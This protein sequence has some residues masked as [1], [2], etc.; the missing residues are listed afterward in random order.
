MLLE[1]CIHLTSANRLISLLVLQMRAWTWVC[2]ESIRFKW[3][4]DRFW[5]DSHLKI[6]DWA[7][8]LKQSSSDRSA[9]CWKRRFFNSELSD[10]IVLSLADIFSSSWASRWE[11]LWRETLNSTELTFAGSVTD[12]CGF[13]LSNTTSTP[14]LSLW[15]N[16]YN[17]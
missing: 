4:D 13:C 16:A 15:M 1:V 8:T 6:L 7:S 5:N 14:D 9:L 2:S 12:E 10:D 17:L 3:S 11:K